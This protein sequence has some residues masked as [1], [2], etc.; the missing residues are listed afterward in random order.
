MEMT[1]RQRMAAALNHQEAD[2][3]PYDLSGTTVTAIC[4][5]AFINAMKE[6]GLSTEFQEMV[7]P[8]QQIITPIEDTLV[9][10]KS[11]T[12]RIGARRIPDFEHV[13]KK[14]GD[15][16]IIDDV[17]GCR[18]ELDE[19]KDFYYNQMTSPLDKY[20]DFT[21][22]LNNYTMPDPLAN[23][24]I[25]KKDWAQ[26]AQYLGDYC[27]IA[28]RNIAGLT[29]M[30]LRIR[31]Y[32]KWYMDIVMD[33]DAVNR[34]LEDF[35]QYK[36][37]YW[38]SL[39]TWLKENGHAE[40]IQVISEADDLGTQKST[41]ISPDDLNE[42]VIPK[43]KRLWSFMKEKMPHTK[44]FL[45]TCGAVRPLLPALIEAGLEIYN[46]VQFTAANMD[47]AGLKRD[48]GKDLVFWG[49]GV[50]TQN[51]LSKGTPEAVRDEVKKILD[52]MAPNGG[53]VF[54]PVHNIQNDISAAN[55]WAM[56]DT[57]QE[58]GKY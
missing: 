52:I 15:V 53:F 56:W 8:I 39:F 29:E 26:Q 24:E 27:G 4:K 42:L 58:Y 40:K 6:R 57:L 34:L 14:V 38:D 16:N 35:L 41:L 19:T 11:D 30:S 23:I 12:R 44:N 28:D 13:N 50:D 33:R 10:L 2:R 55:F 17:W 7:D 54:A 25:N 1:S 20:E 45:H 32:E 3:V 43:F 18:W 37:G 21:E 31:G 48:F 22:A 5:G 46:P 49:G 9:K 36:M 51:T 47:L